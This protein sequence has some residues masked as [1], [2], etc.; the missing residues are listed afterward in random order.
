LRR[1]KLRAARP[2]PIQFPIAVADFDFKF[3]IHEIRNGNVVPIVGTELYV[4]DRGTPYDTLIAQKLATALDVKHVAADATPRDVSL[5]YL[6]TATRPQLAFLRSEYQ[7]A[8]KGALTTPPRALQQLAEI[9]DFRLYVTTAVDRMMEEALRLANRGVATSVAYTLQKHDLKLPD[10]AQTQV[11]AVCHLLGNIDGDFPVGDAELIEYL[12]ALLG[13]TY[14]PLRLYDELQSRNLLFMGCGFPDWLSRL[15]IRTV[16]D[17]PFM[18]SA[19]E[20]RAQFIADSRAANDKNLSLFLTHYNVQLHAAGPPT[21]FVEELH[22]RWKETQAQPKP[23]ALTTNPITVPPGAVF[24]SFSSLDRDTVRDI[25]KAL[26]AAG[27]D[28]WFDE[29]DIEK[30]SEWDPFIEDALLKATLFV[31]FVSNN[32]QSL[33][34]SPKY[35]WKEWN[36]AENR[37]S[38]FAPGTKFVLPIALDPV[39]VAIAHG[40]RSFKDLQWFPLHGRTATPELID[41]IKTE[42]RRR[43]ARPQ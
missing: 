23:E 40:P 13:Q 24:L 32:T 27:I 10:M 30:G 7:T 28:V 20:N 3:L 1:L 2:G 21:K 16:K 22:R 35:F 37:M 18:P 33:A 25:A 36:F 14:R 41:F 42:Y 29:T 38:Y 8:V 39:D 11:P 9:K 12:Q 17:R 5:A 34:N 26:E 31:P 6:A 19:A 15:F 43:Q 4:D